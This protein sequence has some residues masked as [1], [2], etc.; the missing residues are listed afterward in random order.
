[1]MSIAGIVLLY[2]RQ[3]GIPNND[4]HCVVDEV[5]D[6]LNPLN[7]FL[8][9]QIAYARFLIASSSF[10][11][12]CFAVSIFVY[13]L[14]FIRNLRFMLTITLFYVV[15]LIHMFIIHVRFP[16]GYYWND[17]HVLT[18]SVPYGR[19]SDFF[20]SGHCGFLAICFFEWRVRY[21]KQSM[22]V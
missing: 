10:F 2:F 3:H 21:D 12:D 15:R 22:I 4:V 7:Y 6:F 13:W 19:T 18:L 14:F 20:F 8:N 1:M 11:M 16:I 17:P 9:S 5:H